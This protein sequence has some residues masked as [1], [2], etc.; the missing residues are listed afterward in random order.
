MFRRETIIAL[1][2]RHQAYRI[3]SDFVYPHVDV[4]APPLP[5]IPADLEPYYRR[6]LSW[7]ERAYRALLRSLFVVAVILAG[8]L[9]TE[10]LIL[11]WRFL[12]E[13]WGL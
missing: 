13:H 7:R 12:G 4:P 6:R 9:A 11:L 10:L 3:A 1:R 5:A 8:V 2:A